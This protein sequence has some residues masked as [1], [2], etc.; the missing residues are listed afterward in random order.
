MWNPLTSTAVA[1]AFQLLDR[2]VRALEELNESVSAIASEVKA[3][4][5]QLP[6]PEEVH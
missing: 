1:E 6:V 4:R 2:G 5:E 3:L